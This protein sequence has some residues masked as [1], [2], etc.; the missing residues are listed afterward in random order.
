[1]AKKTLAPPKWPTSIGACADLLF[2]IREQRLSQQ[3]LVDELAAK[4][5]A[6]K[7]HV[8]Q[9]LPKGDTG[10]A[11]R[12][13]KVAVITK[14]VPRVEDWTKFYAYIAKTKRFDLMQRRVTDTAVQ[15]MWDS[16]K[17]VPGVVPFQ[18]VSVSLTK[19]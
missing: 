1:M 18:A 19:V 7:E 10:A 2:E 4:E 5:T 8:I 15:E 6:L 14:V 17:Q 11:G 9:S 16:K 13:H 12:H 3:K